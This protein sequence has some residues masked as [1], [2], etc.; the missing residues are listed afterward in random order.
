MLIVSSRASAV[1]RESAKQL[2]S[3]GSG[4]RRSTCPAPDADIRWDV[5][6]GFGTCSIAR[7]APSVARHLFRADV[8]GTTH[9]L[10][11]SAR[12]SLGASVGL[13]S[14]TEAAE[15]GATVEAW[16]ATLPDERN[17]STL[18]GTLIAM[19]DVALRP[20][21]VTPVFT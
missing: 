3:G 19:G 8:D 12:I 1:D 4:S 18:L 17:A 16:R 2:I 11:V 9:V 20:T 5:R 13:A 14:L 7:S 21:A 10:D 15:E 6:S